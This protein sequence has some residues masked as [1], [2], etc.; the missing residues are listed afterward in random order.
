LKF[1]LAIAGLILGTAIACAESPSDLDKHA[2]AT[3]NG[4]RIHYV[5]VGTGE[6]AI[7]VPGWPED[8][9]TWH[10]VAQ[11]LVAAGRKVYMID[12]RG[13]GDSD[14]PTTGYDPDT[15]AAD[16]HALVGALHLTVPGGVDVVG[17]DLGAWISFS[18]STR[19][20]GDVKRL[21]LAEALI[22]GLVLPAGGIPDDATNIKT[23]QFSF[24]RLPDLPEILVQGHER[25]F[26]DWLFAHKTQNR[27]GVDQ[28]SM[29][30][31]LR[32]LSMPGG[33]NFNYFRGFFETG[34]LRQA[35]ASAARGLSMPVL[36]IGSGIGVGDSLRKSLA[37]ITP[38]LSGIV[39]SGCGHYLPEECPDELSDSLLRFWAKSPP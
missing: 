19:Y 7:L 22:P 24:N 34:A 11:K 35:K 32:V 16:L 30:E 1:I 28:A 29:T 8:W 21:V 23:F 10:I 5:V 31:Y 9:F 3:A 2:F 4:I 13:F 14:K 12:P 6:P 36:A 33:A 15:A 17:H 39:I 18:Y 26:L 20:P 27:D 37:P 25:A 38:K